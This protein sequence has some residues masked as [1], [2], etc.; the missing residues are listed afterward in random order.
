VSPATVVA[1]L[2]QAWT[3]AL[4]RLAA[5]APAL[6][7]CVVGVA[8]AGG[9][10]LLGLSAHQQQRLASA[11]CPL[12]A[13]GLGLSAGRFELAGTVARARSLL[14]TAPPGQARPAPDTAQRVCL[15]A[16]EQFLR[17]S[18][19][20]LD[21]GLFMP[22][23][24]LLTVLLVASAQAGPDGARPR[25]AA[26]A[27]GALTALLILDAIENQR[28]LALL[29]QLG[30]TLMQPGPAAAPSPEMERA[31]QNARQ[32]SLVKWAAS[33]LWCVSLAWA[34]AQGWPWAR[35]RGWT[36]LGQRG[37]AVA[38]ALSGLILGT[39]AVWGWIQPDA[40]DS[41]LRG[42]GLGMGAAI[43]GLLLAVLVLAWEQ[44][45][46]PPRQPPTPP[47]ETARPPPEP[48]RHGPAEQDPRHS[49]HLEE[50]RQI[51]SEVVGQLARIEGLARGSVVA[52]AVAYSWLVSESLGVEGK[53]PT[54]CL[55]L[56][57]EMLVFA[58]WL[59][60]ALVL[61]AALLAAVL[62]SR[63]RTTGQYLHRLEQALGQPPLGWEAHL[64]PQR[65]TVTAATAAVWGLLL[66]LSL[67]ATILGQT[68]IVQAD[69][70]CDPAAQDKQAQ[71]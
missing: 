24:A 5:G 27:L 1:W 49:F 7:A 13:D 43:V 35:R 56:P 68:R 11:D 18:Y 2:T 67:S 71:A 51:R 55:R 30:P 59:P 20:T 28:A 14:D 9:A 50:Y 66:A 3:R 21:A 12:S 53:P 63:V 36:R 54:D 40:F 25:V 23:Y 10:A 41:L 58:W 46:R 69:R 57:Q 62:A 17:D 31:A 64:Q 22:L 39:T 48:P 16:R 19:Q 34:V 33:A 6:N 8:L 65:S 52:C 15:A 47:P 60:P 4:A 45:A 37:S 70:A 61:V 32:A 26:A 29:D 42:V 44:L 38:L